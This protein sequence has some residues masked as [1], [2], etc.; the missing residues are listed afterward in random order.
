MADAN[1]QT[2]QPTD[3]IKF[4]DLAAPQPGMTAKL[5]RVMGQLDES[6]ISINSKIIYDIIAQHPTGLYLLFDLS[7][8]EYMNSKAIGYLTDWYGKINNGGGKIVIA[9]PPQNVLEILQTVGI[10]ELVKCY[11]TLDEAK[12]QLF[13]KSSV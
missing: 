3:N 7:K 13:Q 4:E 6:N 8:L 11:N 10:T 12:F 1:A 5:V 9:G 2:P